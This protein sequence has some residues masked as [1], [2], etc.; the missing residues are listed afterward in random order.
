MRVWFPC[1]LIVLG[2]HLASPVWAEPLPPELLDA[3]FPVLRGKKPAQE[4]LEINFIRRL[5]VPKNPLCGLETL[6]LTERRGDKVRRFGLLAETAPGSEEPSV[7]FIRLERMTVNADGSHRAYHPDDPFGR[8]TCE[9]PLRGPATMACALDYL[10]NAEIHVYEKNTRVPQ[11]QSNGSGRSE[12]NPAFAAAWGSL[13]S[14]IAARKNNWVDLGVLFGK[15]APSDTRLYYSKDSN[16]AA[17]FNTSI[18]PFKDGYPC[19]HNGNIKEFFV[20]ATKPHPA[21][22]P[23]GKNDACRTAAYLESTQIPFFVLPDGVFKQLVIGDVAVGIA[24]SGQVMRLALGI[25]GDA[26]P[27][28]QIGEG[29]IQFVKRLSG[30]TEE[31]KNSI[32]TGKLDIKVE[33]KLG[34]VDRLGVLVLGGTAKA[35][36]VDYSRSNIEKVA[37]NAFAKWLGDNQERLQACLNVSTP[38]PLEGHETPD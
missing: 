3:I 21:A 4:P 11:F 8:G 27:A 25:V 31:P 35:F 30:S 14:E 1:L 13:W 5:E 19:Q 2:C 32:D 26:G 33:D 36:G 24:Q 29:S 12:P 10:A 6:D 17:T 16:S 34:A 28:G 23:G 9:K 37:R 15:E 22:S 7:M 20:A 18:I 38:N